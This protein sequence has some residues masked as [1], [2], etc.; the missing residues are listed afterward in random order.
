MSEDAVGHN[1]S[2]QKDHGNVQVYLHQKIGQCLMRDE[3]DVAVMKAPT[4]PCPE[5]LS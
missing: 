5:F 4:R 3:L 1:Y 2:D